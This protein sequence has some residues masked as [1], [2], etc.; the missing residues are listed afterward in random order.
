MR[1][2]AYRI[3][4]VDDDPTVLD[5]LEACFNG[6]L[7]T[8]SS[9]GEARKKLKVSRP[10]L[11]V[12]DRILPDGDGLD[13]CEEVRRDPERRS[14]PVLMLTCKTDPRDRVEG[15]EL[16]ADDYLTKPFEMAELKARIEALLRRTAKLRSRRKIVEP[17]WRY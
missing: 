14:L 13:L 17:L 10:D 2:Q 4:F 12:L 8:A 6:D 16:G 15:L 9:L 11:M 1:K 7:S 5:L 3:L